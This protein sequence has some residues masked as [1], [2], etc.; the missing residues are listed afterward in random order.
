MPEDKNSNSEKIPRV[1]KNEN[2][3]DIFIAES[4]YPEVE[5]IFTA[6]FRTVNEV[7]EDCLVVLDTNAL[8]VPYLIGKDS[9][10]QIRGTYEKLVSEKRLLIPSQVAREFAK[11]RA[12]KLTELYQQFNRKISNINQ[13][14]KG[15]YPLLESL[16]SY[17]KALN[18]ETRIDKLMTDYKKTVKEVL[19]HIKNWTWDDPVSLLYADL[20]KG[21]VLQDLKYDKEEIQVELTRRQIHSIPPGYKDGGKEDNGIGDFLIWR[22]ILE[23]GK[24]REKSLLFVSGEEKPDWFHKSEGQALY[25]RYEL[26]DEY[27]RNSK[28]QSFHIVSFA[29]FLNIF[30]ASK[31]VVE[32]VQEEERKL[33]LE[34]SILG[35]FVRKWAEFERAV[36]KKC[37][38][39]SPKE[40][41]QQFL[42]TSK[43]LNILIK[44]QAISKH[45]YSIA[46][47]ISIIRNKTVHGQTDFSEQMIR[48][49]LESLDELMDEL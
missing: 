26:V 24:T 42:S 32:E 23:A 41:S 49:A 12:N 28:G 47:E 1:R 33:N 30:G 6:K 13:L 27:R 48:D 14:H 40:M 20:L 44:H 29:R 8:L 16:D 39:I 18:L 36:L 46:R 43:M 34:F 19:A 5:P 7:K 3:R 37:N 25:P 10:E 17:E 21:D 15:R 2:E 4:I 22:T 35:E 45:F 38:D 11:N 9:I 31:S